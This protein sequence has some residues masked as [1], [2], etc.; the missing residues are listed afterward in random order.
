[1]AVNY[2]ITGLT[3]HFT[4]AEY[5][6]DQIGTVKLSKEALLQAHCLEEFRR[7]YGKPLTV[8]SWYRTVAC[9]KAV[10]GVPNSSHLYGKATDLSLPNLSQKNFIRYAKKWR[11]ICRKHGV[12]GEAGLYNW[13]MHL[14]SS[15]TYSNRFYHWDSR[16]NSQV[17]M[18]FKD[19]Q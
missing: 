4:L 17:N 19:L 16:G 13:G 11:E 9:N 7:W 2:K 10:G 12:V 8:T 6:V 15:I 14:G 1:M 3:K 18:P 5:S